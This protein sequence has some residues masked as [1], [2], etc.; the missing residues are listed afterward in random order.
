MRGNKNGEKMKS[1]LQKNSWVFT[2]PVAHRG[3]HDANNGEN[4]ME[5]YECA[6]NAGYPIEMDIQISK[7]GVPF[8]FHDDNVKRITGVNKLFNDLTSEEIKELRV[9]GL[10]QKIPTF[11]DFLKLVN[12]KVPL[13]IEI[14]SPCSKQYDSARITVDCLKDYK[15]EFVVQSFDPFIM[16][17]VRKYAPH[18]MRGQLGGVPERGKLSYIKYVAVKNMWFNFLSKPDYINY[19]LPHMP[20]NKKTPTICWTVRTE[21]D[22]ALAKKL[23]VNFVFESVDP[24]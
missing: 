7:D 14:K 12:G 20:I 22:L 16:Q 9:L 4:T 2:A 3:L 15:G 10:G 23:G 17:K 18:I 6:I 19:Y 5:A 21:N 24:N 8:C 1:R 11:E 13:M